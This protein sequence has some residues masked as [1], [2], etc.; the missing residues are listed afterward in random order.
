MVAVPPCTTGMVMPSIPGFPG[1]CPACVAAG[2]RFAGA[3]LPTAFFAAAFFFAGFRAAA[4]FF[5]GPFAAGF[6]GIGMV[7]P[8]MF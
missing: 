1:S 6:A 8:G 5:A 7:M 2:L 3:V 4:F